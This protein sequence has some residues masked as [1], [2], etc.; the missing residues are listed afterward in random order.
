MYIDCVLS[1]SAVTSSIYEGIG[2]SVQEKGSDFRPNR[3]NPAK[4]GFPVVTGRTV[5]LTVRTIRHMAG[6]SDLQSGPSDVAE[7]TFVTGGLI[8]DVRL[9]SRT[10]RPGFP[11]LYCFGHNF[12]IRTRI[13]TFQISKSTGSTRRSRPM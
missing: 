2:L 12:F 6:P 4:L 13:W 11:A 5:R 1:Q 8:P 3:Q 10:V 7:N 9:P